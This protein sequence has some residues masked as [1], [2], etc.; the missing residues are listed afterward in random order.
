MLPFNKSNKD[1][2]QVGIET[3][4]IFIAMI[5]VAA[6][7]AGVLINTAGFLQNKASATSEDSTEQVSNQVLVASAVGEVNDDS[8]FTEANSG[9]EVI[10]ALKFTTMQSPG[11]GEIDMDDATIEYIGPNGKVTLTHADD[12]SA[13]ADNAE[14]GTSTLKDDDSSVPVLNAKDDRMEIEIKLDNPG[15]LASYEDGSATYDTAELRPLAGGESATVR[16]VTQS[17]SQYTYIVNVPESLSSF[18]GA[19]V[20][21]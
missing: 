20:E 7:A 13:S 9:G 10:T 11:A 12:Q 5:L 18:S 21:V 4:I 2:G 17:G 16:F 8:Y 19:S 15:D 1:R 3:L 14:F 6:V